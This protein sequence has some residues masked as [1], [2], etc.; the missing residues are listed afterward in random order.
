MRAFVR[1]ID[2][3]LAGFGI[4]ILGIMVI[5][6]VWQ[7]ISRYVLSTPSVGTDEAAR[8]FFMCL[9][10]IGGAYTAGQRR[11]LAIDL[12]PNYMNP[13]SRR[14][15]GIFVEIFVL[16]FAAVILFYG[17][18]MLAI[19]T[20]QSNQTSPVMG[21]PMGYIYLSIPIS[22]ALIVFYSIL[23]IIEQS[24]GVS[25]RETAAPTGPIDV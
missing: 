4:S 17:G 18:G 10:L 11:H 2:M 13:Q 9:G 8:L 21:V 19:D 5:C 14:A 25:F 7:V 22:G 23:T 12:L 15:L 1:F 6:V 24:F 16:A 3:V 20:F